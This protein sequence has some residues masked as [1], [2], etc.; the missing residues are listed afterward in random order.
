M[1]LGHAVTRSKKPPPGKSRGG[2][3]RLLLCVAALSLLEAVA[4]AGE[5]MMR[6]TVSSSLLS[7]TSKGGAMPELAAAVEEGAVERGG[8]GGGGGGG[9]RV[10]RS[11]IGAPLVGRHVLWGG[12]GLQK[13]EKEKASAVVEVIQLDESNFIGMLTEVV[14][15]YDYVLLEFYSH[16]CPAC[17]AFQPEYVKVARRVAEVRG[18]EASLWTDAGVESSSSSSSSS[19]KTG[20]VVGLAEGNRP[21]RLGVARVDCPENKELCDDFLIERYP[22]MLVDTP[23]HFS[24][25][26]RDDAVELHAVPRNYAGV[27]DA[28]EK[29]LGRSFEEVQLPGNKEQHHSSGGE[30]GRMATNHVVDEGDDAGLDDGNSKKSFDLMYP[31]KMATSKTKQRKKTRNVVAEEDLIAGTMLSFDYLR[32]K[33]L[34]HGQEARDTLVEWLHVL[35]LSHPIERCAAGAADVLSVLDSFWPER[36]NA[37]TDL[38]FLRALKICGRPDNVPMWAGCAGSLPETRGYTCGLWQLIHSLS[39][40]MKE[41]GQNSGAGWLATLRN[42]IGHFFQCSDCAAHFV[43]YASEPEAMGVTTKDDVIMWLWRT[44][45]KLNERLRK[46]QDEAGTGDPSFPHLQWPMSDLCADCRN[47]DNSW[48]EDAVK[49]FLIRYYQ[50]TADEDQLKVNPRSKMEQFDHTMHE[51]HVEIESASIHQN[52]QANV[53]PPQSVSSSWWTAWFIIVS[54][55]MVVYASVRNSGSYGYQQSVVLRG[56]KK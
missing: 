17:K 24:A 42:F 14:H 6:P 30:N 35:S 19:S 33:A 54:V 52:A 38:E 29:V 25:K 10:P 36:S 21:V 47:E 7:S 51:R 56:F 11:G 37:V 16:W 15:D 4:V 5:A 53:S 3:P 32:S 34:L 55:C 8:G 9:A 41:E 27:M 46:E 31:P 40:R 13:E 26:S 1:M 39:V 20:G 12:G 44:H 22:T 28:L 2:T 45:N 50:H 43:Q 18:R 49:D 48:N 23:L